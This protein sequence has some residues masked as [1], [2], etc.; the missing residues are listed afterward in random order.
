MPTDRPIDGTIGKNVVSDQLTLVFSCVSWTFFDAFV[1]YLM[2]R[3]RLQFD[4]YL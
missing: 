3:L 2:L 1:V 4:T